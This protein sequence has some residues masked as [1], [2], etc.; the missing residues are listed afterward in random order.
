M[1]FLY[2]GGL[3][4][5]MNKI[6]ASGDSGH[7]EYS[8][9]GRPATSTLNAQGMPTS[10]AGGSLRVIVQDEG[11]TY[12]S[13][14]RVL[15]WNGNQTFTLSGAAVDTG[16][17]IS[18]SHGSAYVILSNSVS[19]KTVT[20]TLTAT[21][22]NLTE[23]IWLHEDDEATYDAQKT[24]TT[25]PFGT[26]F[27]ET[28]QDANPGVIRFL[29]WQYG[30][31]SNIYN[32]SQRMPVDHYM[33]GASTFPSAL[34]GG[35]LGG[36]SPTFTATQS[37]FALVDGATVIVDITAATTAS[38]T[39]TLNVSET[40]AKNIKL[41]DG[42]AWSRSATGTNRRA[43]FTYVAVLD[44][45]LFLSTE[46]EEGLLGGVPPEVMIDLCNQIGAH[47]HFVCP[48]LACDTPSDYMQEFAEYAAATL[49]EGLQFR[50]EQG[51]NEFWN[52]SFMPTQV[53]QQIAT[54]RYGG[55]DTGRINDLYGRYGALIGNLV[56]TAFGGDTSRYAILCGVQ[57]TS[58]PDGVSG[59]NTSRRIESTRHVAAGGTAASAYITDVCP[60]NYWSTLKLPGTTVGTTAE[61]YIKFV[62]MI[63]QARAWDEG[64]AAAK[65]AA[66][67]WVFEDENYLTWLD[68]QMVERVARW[69]A[70]AA[71]YDIGL[72]FY[73]GNYYPGDIT[74]AACH[75]I[76]GVTPGNPTIINISLIN[77][78]QA[79]AFVAGMTCGFRNI[80]GTTQLNGNTYDVLSADATT[81]TIDVDSTAFGVFTSGGSGTWTM[82]STSNAGILYP[83]YG[84]PITQPGLIHNFYYASRFAADSYYATLHCFN[85][86]L[87]YSR[88]EYPSD[89]NMGGGVGQ[90]NK[91]DDIYSTPSPQWDAMKIFG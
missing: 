75:G 65:L 35:T 14:R 52:I 21:D 86:I 79:H 19:P 61:N 36:A 88:A 30:N 48:G 26:K 13:G 29:D 45:Y 76:D 9:G 31:T 12:R 17:S 43:T 20:I 80:G 57:T 90:W 39:T 44:C 62:R 10:V 5:F 66:I 24:A 2:A 91:F 25:E 23:L 1:N 53:G 47:G 68:D 34:R 32:W 22:G 4:P 15:R 37:G 59:A 71:Q 8:A 82:S 56:S 6:K 7:W 85:L 50:V 28:L 49:E 69:H 77:G 89:F 63:E 70:V 87:G 55:S 16:E 51:P 64:D 41:S 18:G 81:V 78:E 27:L 74:T 38:G 72:T 67:N 3:F 33:Y 46:F 11:L 58:T 84:G 83:G 54:V 60:A 42:T 73:E 40:G